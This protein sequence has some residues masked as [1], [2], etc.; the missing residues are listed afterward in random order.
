MYKKIAGGGLSFNFQ[1]RFL[2]T[3]IKQIVMKKINYHLVASFVTLIC[4]LT[5]N[6]QYGNETIVFFGFAENKEM[7]I[8]LDNPVT[9]SKIYVTPGSKVQEGDILMEVSRAGLE[10]TQS[11]LNHEVA[12]LQSQLQLWEA[13]IKANISRLSALKDARISEINNQIDQLESEMNINQSLIKDLKSIQPAKDQRGSSPYQ[14]KV[15]GLK[16]ELKL[17]V[18]PL[19]SEIRKLKAELAT[20]ENPLRIQINKLLEELGFVQEEEEKLKIYATSHGIVGSIF[21]K[22]GEQISAFT[23]LMTFYEENP[24]QIKGYVLE[25]LMLKVKMGDTISVNSTVKE[26]DSLKGAIIGMGSRIV[27]IPERLRKNPAFKTYG[28][29]VIIRIPFDNSF[30]QSEKVTCKIIKDQ[31]VFSIRSISAPVTASVLI[32]EEDQIILE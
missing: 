20:E 13:N 26:N 30:L 24:T 31:D 23:T 3:G 12:K 2:L 9:I 22:I 15:Q 21:C 19:E 6:W 27:E 8:R 32:S 14:I 18:K 28:R 1:G 29:E 25:N 17:S 7:E 5:F 10:L 11:D 16:K 4:L